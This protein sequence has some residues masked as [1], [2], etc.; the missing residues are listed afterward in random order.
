MWR[1]HGLGA[2]AVLTCTH[3]I[4]LFGN[5]AIAGRVLFTNERTRSHKRLERT[6]CCYH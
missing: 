3:L 4:T 6:R 1:G 5:L 2:E